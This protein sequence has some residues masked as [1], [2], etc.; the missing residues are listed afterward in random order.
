MSIKIFIL[1]CM[2]FC[3]I[4][5]DYYLQGV[6]ASM[7]QKKWWSEHAPDKMYKYDYIVALIMHGFSWAFMVHLP[8]LFYS[9]RIMN[10]NGFMMCLFLIPFHALLHSY[11][12]DMKANKRSINLICD[13]MA[14]MMQIASSYYII[15]FAACK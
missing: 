9:Y 5:D 15:V 12:D 8:L 11:I 14:H 10:V 3:H 13:Q 6:L 1:L 4:V 7:K 2:I